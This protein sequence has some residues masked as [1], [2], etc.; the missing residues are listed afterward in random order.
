MLV[1]DAWAFAL[2]RITHP[3]FPDKVS[4]CARSQAHIPPQTVTAVTNCAQSRFLVI[5]QAVTNSLKTILKNVQF[6]SIDAGC[7]DVT[8]Q[9]STGP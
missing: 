4:G 6:A 3:Q 5:F 8:V 1:A 7:A 9:C 2:C